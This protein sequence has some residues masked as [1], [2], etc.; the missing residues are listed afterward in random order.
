MMMKSWRRFLSSFGSEVGRAILQ[1]H[2][3]QGAVFQE[4]GDSGKFTQEISIERFYY[5]LLVASFLH[6]KQVHHDTKNQCDQREC[7]Q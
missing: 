1:K 3:H 4:R 5:L 2:H 7:Q 6:N